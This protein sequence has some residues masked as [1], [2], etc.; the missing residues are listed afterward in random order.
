[1][2]LKRKGQRQIGAPLAAATCALL[3]QAAP[4]EIVAQEL[5]PW[6]VD[7][8]MLIYSESDSRVRDLSLNAIARKELREDGFLNLT[9]ALDTLTGAS[10]S[11]AVPSTGVQ[12]FTRPSGDAQY[13]IAA[14]E[15]PLDDT[16][17]DTRTALSASWE[18][19]VTRLALL[20]VGAS[21]S[22][23]Y[24]YTHT[25]INARIARDFNNRN[26]TLSFGAALANDT[27]DPV[28]GTP[29]ALAPML[30]IGAATYKRGQGESKDVL[31]LLIGV[32]QV[33]NRRTVVQFNY[34]LSE[35]DG[36]LTDPYKILSV[37]DP[38]TGNPVLGPAGSGLNRYLFES[39]P[40]TRDKDSLFALVKRDFNGDV[41]DV[42]YRYMTDDWGV[43]SHTF[44][45]HYR[46]SFG[47]G[48]YVQPHVRFYTQTAADFYTTVLFTGTALPAYATA[49]YRLGEFDGITFG[50]KYGRETRRGEFSTRVEWY[51]QTGQAS[52]GAAVGTLAG[53]DLYPDLNALIAQ[54]TYK[55][56]RR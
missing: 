3:G 45:V 36:Y 31:D 1:M 12:T 2:Q 32:T 24:D 4:G 19:P 34:S 54:F 46:W 41:L 40:A 9:L 18:W 27:I 14:T 28:G 15:Q 38:V 44:D 23:E 10:P 33:L 37:V 22:D 56:G 7:T 39:R 42:S 25:G 20:S 13:V 5:A 43:E 50:V 8:S 17:Q 51:T 48:Q 30:G 47:S 16:F 49:D 21:L 26:T 6:D 53:L 35:A 11:G 29:V 52:P 55:F